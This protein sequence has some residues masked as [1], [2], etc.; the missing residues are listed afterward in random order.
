MDIYEL[1]DIIKAML[2]EH[3]QLS[4]AEAV[5]AVQVNTQTAGYLLDK[6]G[7]EAPEH[8]K[9]GK[10]TYRVLTEDAPRNFETKQQAMWYAQKAWSLT[11]TLLKHT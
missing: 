3:P 5:K 9:K 1:Q 7:V 6:E 4:V 8:M 11:T 2:K 10:T